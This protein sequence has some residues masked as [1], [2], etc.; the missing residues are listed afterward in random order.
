MLKVLVMSYNNFELHSYIYISVSFNKDF[1]IKYLQYDKYCSKLY[2]RIS[3]NKNIF[4]LNTVFII[5]LKS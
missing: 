5:I 4:I 2:I 1:T 3:T